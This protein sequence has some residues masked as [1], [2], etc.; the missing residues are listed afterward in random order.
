MVSTFLCFSG[1]MNLKPALELKAVTSVAPVPLLNIHVDLSSFFL[2]GSHPCQNGLAPS[3]MKLQTC[4]ND[5][6]GIEWMIVSV[7]AIGQLGNCI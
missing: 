6:I 5:V 1:S 2:N 4:F 7:I 3:K